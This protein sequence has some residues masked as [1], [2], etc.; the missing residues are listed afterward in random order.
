MLNCHI[1]FLYHVLKVLT[2]LEVKTL[3]SPL[4]K[5]KCLLLD[6]E[7]NKWDL[8]GIASLLQ[9]SPFLE[10][11]VIQLVTPYNFEVIFS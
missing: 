11:L 5:R 7:L 10:K 2:I 8:P 9:S 6:T 3:P 4:A 1:L